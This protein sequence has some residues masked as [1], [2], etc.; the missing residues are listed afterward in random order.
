MDPQDPI[1]FSAQDQDQEPAVYIC[2]F[3]AVILD[4]SIWLL[5]SVIYRA[6]KILFNRC[7][8]LIFLQV[9][10]WEVGE[11]RDGAGDCMA[12]RPG[13]GWFARE[14]QPLGK[15]LRAFIAKKHH[16]GSITKT[17]SYKISVFYFFDQKS[18]EFFTSSL[19]KCM[20]TLMII[21]EKGSETGFG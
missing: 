14:C 13:A 9:S 2:G 20:P 16:T 5:F 6:L 15:V 3:I 10:R 8:D 21:L 19:S 11:P 1:L 12:T 17:T 7:I 4:N 18:E